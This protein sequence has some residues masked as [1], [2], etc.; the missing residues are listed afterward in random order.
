MTVFQVQRFT[1]DARHVLVLA[2]REALSLGHNHIGTEHLL[3]G[4][5]DASSGVAAEVLVGS[6]V[7]AGD[8]RS[9][10]ERSVGRCR[11]LHDDAA[12]L[13]A[14]GID[15]DQVR[16]TVEEAF[17]PGALESAPRSRRVRRRR[18]RCF[19]RPGHPPFTPRSKKVLEQALRKSLDLNHDHI[20]A[21]HVLL[22][23]LAQGEGLACQILVQ[24]GARLE[25]IT[26]HTLVA[27]GKVA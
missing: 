21:E 13:R 15:L 16:A 4:L 24:G 5:L 3:L 22:G 18:R 2:Q 17:G 10:V 25:D 26:R 9:T 20:G 11:P 6:G 7:N 12:A 19:A 1:G 14:I 23:L 8:V 27:L